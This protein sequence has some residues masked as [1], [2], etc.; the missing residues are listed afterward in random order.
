M[1]LTVAVESPMTAA[2]HVKA[3]A[4]FNEKNPQPHVALFHLGPRS[5]RA[6]V[7]TRIRLA[8]SQKL[9]AIAEMSDGSFWS[10]QR[11]RRS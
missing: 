3:I 11:R 10:G 7:A 8:N 9:V 6:R 4:V 1:P 5:G 2:D